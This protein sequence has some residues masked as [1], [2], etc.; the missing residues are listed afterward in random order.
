MPKVRVRTR[1]AGQ[2]ARDALAPATV[3]DAVLEG[4]DNAMLGGKTVEELAVELGCKARVDERGLDTVLGSQS[5]LP[6]ARPAQRNRQARARQRRGP[7]APRCSERHCSR[8]L[9]QAQG[10]DG[11]PSQ[12]PVRGL[13]RDARGGRAT[14][15]AWTDIPP[16][17]P[18]PSSACWED[19][20][21]WKYQ[22]TK[23]ASRTWCQR[24][25]HQTPK[26][27]PG[28]SLRHRSCHSSS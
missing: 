21:A 5:G 7:D 20:P 14:S 28:T 3:Q 24:L 19:R 15:S 16:C 25:T 2:I 13:P 4:D 10:R 8:C 18:A 9:R 11:L 23:G 1:R 6:R 27:L 17:R 12:C 22:R 26:W